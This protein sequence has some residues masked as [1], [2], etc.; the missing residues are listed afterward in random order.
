M[1]ATVSEL[2]TRACAAR[3]DVPAKIGPPIP[4]RA[5]TGPP[6]VTE[7]SADNR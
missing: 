3:S 1:T 6:P 2:M 4:A 7:A 5:L